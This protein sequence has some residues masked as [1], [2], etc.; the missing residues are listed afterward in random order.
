MPDALNLKPS[1]PG[2]RGK[3]LGHAL[4]CRDL[5]RALRGAVWATPLTPPEPQRKGPQ[6]REPGESAEWGPRALHS[7]W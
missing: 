6:T 3:G 2:G 4:A 7:P 1:R 5:R